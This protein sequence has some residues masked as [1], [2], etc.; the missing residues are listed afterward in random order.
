MCS[1]PSDLWCNLDRELMSLL[2]ALGMQTRS[3]PIS[4]GDWVGGSRQYFKMHTDIL[5]IQKSPS[6]ITSLASLFLIYL[7]SFLFMLTPFIFPS[8]GWEELE[9]NPTQSSCPFSFHLTQSFGDTVVYKIMFASE[10]ESKSWHTCWHPQ[11]VD[12]SQYLYHWGVSVQVLPKSEET[13]AQN[14]RN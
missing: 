11:N 10:M 12:I 9:M 13:R 7:N 5:I 6:V 4:L 1:P 8:S 14:A 3:P 2:S